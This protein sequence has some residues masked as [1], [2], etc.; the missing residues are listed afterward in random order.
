MRKNR[1]VW[2]RIAVALCAMLILIYAIIRC[3]TAIGKELEVQVGENLHDVASQNVL[4]LEREIQDKQNL[5]NSIAKELATHTQD[6]PEEIL[7]VLEPFIDSYQF[8]RM[9]FV[10]TD[11]EAYTTDGFQRSLAFREFFQQSMEGKEYVTGV[12][13]DSL[14]EQENI[15]VFSVPV[16]GRDS[17]TVE[18]VLFATY[19]TKMFQDLMNV[20]SFN[21][22]GNSDI[23]EADGTIITEA[24]KLF[25]SDDVSNIFSAMLKADQGNASVVK[26]MTNEMNEGKSGNASFMLEDK[27]YVY[28]M[29]LQQQFDGKQ[30]YML[31]IVPSQVLDTRR[32]PVLSYVNLLLITIVC[33]LGISCIAY[34]YSYRKGKQKLMRLAY[35][36]PLTEGDNYACFEA[37]ME[38]RKGVH[39]FLV[40]M[41]LSEFKIVNNTCGVEKGDEALKNVWSILRRVLRQTE[42]A[43]RINADHFVLYLLEEKQENVEARLDRITDMV[44]ELQ[45]TL[46]IPRLSP[47]FGIYPTSNQE[48][49]E[50]SYSRANEAKHLVK[51]RHDTNYAFYDEVDFQ[52]IVS[53]KELEDRF[54][55]AIANHEF[56]IWYQ[57]K[58]STDNATIV[59]AEALTRWRNSDGTLIPPYQFI[60]LFEKNGM[61]SVLD[62][63]V[64]RTVCEQQKKWEREKKP[65]LPVSIN[66]SRASLYYSNVVEKYKLILNEYDIEAKYVPLEITE[67]ATIDNMEIRNLIDEFHSAGFPLLLDDFGNGY[68]SLATLNVMHFD[69]LKLDKS[70][71]DYIGDEKGEKLLY[72]T[73]KLAKS[74]GMQITAEG[75]ECVEQVVFLQRLKCNDIQG[76]YFSKPLPLEEYQEKLGAA[77]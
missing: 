40:S 46:H 16:Y 63:Y 2:I 22:K 14:G 62:E 47:Y 30:C 49:V 66:I 76:Y 5:L 28:Y 56:E 31:T 1:T 44:L 10:Y 59:G 36:D 71:I 74:L 26:K 45:E 37:R 11:G 77:G 39:G 24:S 51:G 69:I 3:R 7:R 4:A 50:V 20:D 32:L 13:M 61:I 33:V 8:K 73:I 23:V 55:E 68:S 52:K 29:P 15:N 48:P 19:R 38:S 75:V 67:S 60:P 25:V 72:Y 17:K 53:E 18:G 9:G 58:Y 43:A 27:N 42:L 12:I 35:Q 41:D 21:G 6:K 64:F 57:P 54:E 65:M 34:V 70:L